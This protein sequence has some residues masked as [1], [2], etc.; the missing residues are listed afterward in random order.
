MNTGAKYTL[1]TLLGFFALFA[2]V[3][4]Y[5]EHDD[6][7]TL[8]K[9]KPGDSLHAALRK[10]KNCINYN[11]KTIKWRRT[12]LTTLLSIVLIFGLFRKKFPSAKE[13]LI[14][15]FFIFMAFYINWEHY[16]YRTASGAAKYADENIQNIKKLCV[17]D[18]KFILPD[19]F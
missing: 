19:N 7:Y 9:A 1:I 11:Q 18:H 5:I 6:A 17:K 14:Y 15:F 13:L 3:K 12:L 16:V 8:N 10:L 2:L 4:E